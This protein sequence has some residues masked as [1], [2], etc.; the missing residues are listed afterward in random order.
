MSK[1]WCSAVQGGIRLVVH[2]TPNA[3]KSEVTGVQEDAL[4]IRLHAQPIEGK[5]NE[6]LIRFV[7]DS[8]DIPKSAVNITH[9]HTNKRKILEIKIPSL[10]LPNIRAAFLPAEKLPE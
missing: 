9:G 10:Q 8:L 1:E 4:K 2:V 5:A 6:A 7:A 3:K